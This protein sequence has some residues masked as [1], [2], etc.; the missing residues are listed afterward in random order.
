MELIYGILLLPW[1]IVI[2][3]AE[4]I[5]PCERSS[6]GSCVRDYQVAYA[7]F[8]AGVAFVDDEGTGLI[9]DAGYA[10]TGT[11]GYRVREHIRLDGRLN[12]TNV[13]VK[14]STIEVARIS[15][16]WNAYYDF[17][18]GI[19]LTPYVGA[20]LGF[21]STRLESTGISSGPDFAWN[22]IGGAA[23]S[24]TEAVDLTAEY[25]YTDTL[26][27]QFESHELLVGVRYNFDF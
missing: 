18:L 17:D 16:I 26:D 2:I 19:P 9:E 11:L 5:D 13:G 20:G 7:G 12:Y 1:A 8:D 22:A 23:Y 21:G 6:D 25:R 10:L 15:G 3:G 4:V 27:A 24:V 14:G